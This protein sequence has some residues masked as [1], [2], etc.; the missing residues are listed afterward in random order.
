MNSCQFVCAHKE[1]DADA[2]SRAIA[3]RDLKLIGK[4]LVSGNATPEEITTGGSDSARNIASEYRVGASSRTMSRTAFSTA[5]LG[6]MKA[7]LCA[8]RATWNS[9]Q[10]KGGGCLRAGQ[11]AAAIMSLIGSAKIND[12]DPYAYL[13][14]VLTRLPTHPA[15]RIAELLRHRWRSSPLH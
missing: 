8:C 6:E 2:A 14:D 9:A 7:R 11:R 12:L 15:S 4:L 5:W 3:S 13:S 1:L 10:A